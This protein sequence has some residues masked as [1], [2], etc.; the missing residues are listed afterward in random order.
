MHLSMGVLARGLFVRKSVCVCERERDGVGVTS[1]T[2]FEP[3][4]G[5]GSGRDVTA[6]WNKHTWAHQQRY[7]LL[8]PSP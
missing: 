4:E 3:E 5:G 2:M 6:A 1:S 7:H 8:L